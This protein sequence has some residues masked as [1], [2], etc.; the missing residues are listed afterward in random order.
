M[1]F[2][3]QPTGSLNNLYLQLDYLTQ[4][5]PRLV[6]CYLHAASFPETNLFAEAPQVVVP[7]AYGDYRFWGG[8]RLWHAPEAMPRTY[9][10]DD[11]GLEVTRLPDGVRLALP[12]H[13]AVGI[14]K[15]LEV[16]L[17]PDRPVLNLVHEL[18]NDGAWPVE[19]APWALT[20]LG[21]G[22]VVVFPQPPA[23]ESLLPNRSLVL[24]PYTRLHDPRLEL[25][26]DLI[27]LHA[28]PA[29]PPAKLGYLNT[30]GW[31]GYLFKDV[32]LRKRFAVYPDRPHA[33][34]GCNVET[35]CNH[36]MVELE[37]LGPL[38]RLEPGR[39]VV[40]TETWE[41]YTGLEYPPTLAGVRALVKEVF[42]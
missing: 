40:H 5:G 18:R 32:F 7:T 4:G 10:P 11:A 24:W 8:H 9:T 20:M 30:H 37:T 2:H 22:G 23:V 33:D 27:L 39:S 21:L 34:R 28:E 14:W 3:G 17:L 25:D 19:A 36:Q 13:P 16:H 26:D 38:A 1:D 41:F 35:Y 15:S 31:A 29:Q 12:A 42:G 6:R